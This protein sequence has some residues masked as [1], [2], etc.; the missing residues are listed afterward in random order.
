[1]FEPNVQAPSVGDNTPARRPSVMNTINR[2][3]VNMN[4]CPFSGVQIKV[5][6]SAI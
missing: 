6:S 2:Q 1:M 4:Q 3:S 5:E